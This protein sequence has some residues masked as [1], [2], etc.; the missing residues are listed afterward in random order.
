MVNYWIYPGYVKIGIENCPFSSLIYLLKMVIFQ[1]T[2]LVYQRVHYIEIQHVQKWLSLLQ[3]FFFK[4]WTERQKV[5]TL[6]Y[7]WVSRE[8]EHHDHSLYIVDICR[9]TIY[10][11]YDLHQ[12]HRSTADSHTGQPLGIPVLIRCSA[13]KPMLGFVHRY[14]GVQFHLISGC[15]AIIIIIEAHT[16][17]IVVQPCSINFFSTKHLVT[18]TKNAKPNSNNS[19]TSSL[20]SEQPSFN[21]GAAPNG[22]LCGQSG[23]HM[24]N[25][26]SV[27][28]CSNDPD[29]SPRRFDEKS[30]RVSHS[31]WSPKTA[32]P[33]LA[34]TCLTGA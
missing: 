33:S 21:V 18:T 12:G 13:D 23:G 16:T 15:M 3:P 19:L 8:V 20:L 5:T 26:S 2:M 10:I 6:Y 27:G 1:F 24:S 31:I 11:I 7:A 4:V 34:A 22:R 25:P 28:C 29:E 9:C 14:M 17:D 32:V 30:H